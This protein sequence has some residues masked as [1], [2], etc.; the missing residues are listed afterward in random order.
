[1][2]GVMTYN[3]I[4][5]PFRKSRIVMKPILDAAER[6]VIWNEWHVSISGYVVEQEN[7]ESLDEGD[8]IGDA[9]S[10]MED[11]KAKLSIQRRNSSSSASATATWC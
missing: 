11:I 4:E 10:V 3:G 2:P 5:V 9:S 1:M 7:A 6:S 8:W